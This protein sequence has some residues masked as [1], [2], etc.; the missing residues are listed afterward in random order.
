MSQRSTPV[1]YVISKI[2]WGLS[3]VMPSLLLSDARC[4]KLSFILIRIS[5]CASDRWEAHL[6]S[7]L[8]S[9]TGDSQQETGIYS[10]SMMSYE[11]MRQSGVLLPNWHRVQELPYSSE[12][13]S[14]VVL[15]P[16]DNN[17]LRL[18]IEIA[19][20]RSIDINQ[21]LFLFSPVKKWY[22]D[23]TLRFEK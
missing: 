23:W 2:Q 6:K 1:L 7:S 13:T 14:I 11:M 8:L 4:P 16:S 12:K 9:I 5:L 19:L 22:L 15:L 21:K 3:N 20:V 18:F 10:I 17:L